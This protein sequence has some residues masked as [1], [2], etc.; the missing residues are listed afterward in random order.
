MSVKMCSGLMTLAILGA[1]GGGAEVEERERASLRTVGSA[2]GQNDSGQLVSYELVAS[3]TKAQ[4]QAYFDEYVQINTEFGFIT[5][6]IPADIDYGADTYKITYCTLDADLANEPGGRRI[7]A[8]TGNLTVPRKS[9]PL[10]VVLYTHGT[11]VSYYDA[12]SNPSTLDS[13]DGPA[14]TSIYA[15]GG[16][17]LVA[18]DYIGLGGSTLVPHRYLHAQTEASS[19]VDMWRAS[20]KAMNLLSVNRGSKLFLMGFS[21]GGHA[22][23]AALRQLQSEG[24]NVTAVGA[25]GSVLDPEAFFRYALGVTEQGT[26][27]PLYGTYP[28]VAYD[29]IYGIYASTAAAFRPAYAPIVNDLFNMQVFFD[30]VNASLGPTMKLTLKPAF[31]SDLKTNPHS[32]MRVRLRQNAVDEWHI[33]P[34]TPIREYHSRDDAEVAY[35]DTVASIDKL[36]ARGANIMVKDAP[37]GYSHYDTWY[38]AM[39]KTVTWFRSF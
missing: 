36:R 15:G 20:K 32:E 5:V 13:F 30:D 23:F 19:T 17:V 35:D 37:A 14:A 21:A 39:P 9:G 4:L 34:G 6:P 2:C 8:A 27:F 28:I 25:T 18:P 11:S 7:T 29:K 38:Q 26:Y 1:C 33:D 3:Y 24:V 12:P 16:F 22:T 31:Y 10:Q